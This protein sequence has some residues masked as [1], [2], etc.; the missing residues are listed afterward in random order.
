[1]Y[2]QGVHR[3]KQGQK[4]HHVSFYIGVNG[5]LKCNTLRW[6]RHKSLNR[7]HRWSS[8]WCSYGEA[9]AP[10]VRQYPNSPRIRF[11]L[12]RSGSLEIDHLRVRGI[13]NL[14]QR[15]S[16]NILARLV[17]SRRRASPPRFRNFP[18]H[19]RRFRK[20]SEQKT[21][22]RPFPPFR[23]RPFSESSLRLRKGIPL[24]RFHRQFRP[25]FPDRV[26]S[27]RNKF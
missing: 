14:L 4:H 22:R 18:T 5:H 21:E 26:L 13:P 10:P 2:R 11:F 3:G 8:P 23:S 25:F 17:A 1:M 7:K 15:L 20:D 9:R 24:R 6:L 12:F 16:P 19:R 27:P